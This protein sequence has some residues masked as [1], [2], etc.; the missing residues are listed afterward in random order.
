MKVLVKQEL[1]TLL[2]TAPS[3]AQQQNVGLGEGLLIVLITPWQDPASDI[4]LRQF[5]ESNLS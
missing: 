4:L 5:L 1:D 3:P 2:S